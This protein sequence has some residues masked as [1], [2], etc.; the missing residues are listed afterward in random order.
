MNR[1][2]ALLMVLVLAGCALIKPDYKRLEVEL[3][4]AW[5]ESAQNPARNGNWWS[6]YSDPALE[7]LIDEALARNTDLAQAVARVDEARALALQVDSAF[8]PQ[9]DG[10]L[11]RSRTLSSAATGLLPPGISS[12][13]RAISSSSN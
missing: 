13:K 4:A 12:R 3:P 8:Y 10:A 5:T 6:I 1:A 7:K 9:V 11:V 2:I